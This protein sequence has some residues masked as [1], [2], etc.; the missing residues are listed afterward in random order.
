MHHSINSL[1]HIFINYTTGNARARGPLGPLVVD[2][3]NAG[4]EIKTRQGQSM[5]HPRV[6][7]RMVRL[8]SSAH[9]QATLTTALPFPWKGGGRDGSTDPSIRAWTPLALIHVGAC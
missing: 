9:L 2:G 6:P 1:L 7:S 4:L 8:R 3:A 5:D